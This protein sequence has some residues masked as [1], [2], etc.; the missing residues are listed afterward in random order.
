MIRCFSSTIHHAV[1]VGETVAARDARPILGR[2]D[3]PETTTRCYSV[4][5]EPVKGNADSGW[6]SSGEEWIGPWAA[7]RPPQP[8]AAR[9]CSRTSTFSRGSRAS[10]RPLPSGF[11]RVTGS[12]VPLVLPAFPVGELPEEVDP[13]IGDP[14]RVMDSRALR[15]RILIRAPGARRRIRH[16]ELGASRLV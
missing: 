6:A 4:D 3:P 12:T 11:S 15:E 8:L 9:A 13:A 16:H 7:S 14:R 10:R 5:E 1:L 2:A